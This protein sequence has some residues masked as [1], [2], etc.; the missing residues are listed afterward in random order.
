MTANDE[1][2]S[3][4]RHLLEDLSPGE[5]LRAKVTARRRRRRRQR[6]ILGISGTA[7]VLVASIGVS[8]VLDEDPSPVVAEGRDSAAAC[9][10][11][12]R[13]MVPTWLPPGWSTEPVSTAE[14]RWLGPDGAQI[15]VIGHLLRNG[16]DEIPGSVTTVVED[17]GSAVVSAGDECLVSVSGNG[18]SGAELTRVARSLVK[19]TD[20]FAMWPDTDPVEE[21]RRI[22]IDDNDAARRSDPST[23]AIEFVR[24]AL[25]WREVVSTVRERSAHHA[26]VAVT[27]N[28]SGVE[29]EVELRSRPGT[30]PWSV[31]QVSTFPADHPVEVSIDRDA[32]GDGGGSL[33]VRIVPDQ[34]AA[35][36]EVSFRFGGIGGASAY[37]E[38]Q[39]DVMGVDWDGSDSW[40]PDAPGSVLVRFF[41]G[42]GAA[43]AAWGIAVPAGDYRSESTIPPSMT[44]AVSDVARVD[45]AR[46]DA[47]RRRSIITLG[48]S[49]FQVAGERPDFELSGPVTIGGS[50]SAVGTLSGSVYVANAAGGEASAEMVV[51]VGDD[52]GLP[53]RFRGSIESEQTA[54]GAT[55][56]I[57]RGSYSI[58]SGGSIGVAVSGDADLTFRF[59]SEGPS[60][61]TLEL[62]AHSRRNG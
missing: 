54:A 26:V 7:L 15:E 3:V 1:F 5:A 47:A 12:G 62:R 28:A 41:D 57:M 58:P 61:L 44:G 35:A 42:A 21:L 30:G 53:I 4:V 32:G 13:D 48:G 27:D 18:V 56:W 23:V 38:D 25:E 24:E 16:E 39:P 11:A 8:S 49:A 50:A 19:R 46:E 31:F 59:A 10:T 45:A 37:Q 17:G 43:I 36:S 9:A 40:D 20:A 14:R 29:A 34:P 6:R 51:V 2:G 22:Q 55:T 33:Q 52:P 60:S